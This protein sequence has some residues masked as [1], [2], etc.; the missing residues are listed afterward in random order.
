ML[1]YAAG[2]RQIQIEAFPELQKRQFY[3]Q[4][5]ISKNFSLGK[6]ICKMRVPLNTLPLFPTPPSFHS[7][8]SKNS[9]E[10][11][12]RNYFRSIEFCNGVTT[13]FNAKLLSKSQLIDFAQNQ[14]AYKTP[15]IIS[16]RIVNKNPRSLCLQQNQ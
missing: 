11:K 12:I 7:I 6:V 5:F 14:F 8:L 4:N 1:N 10:T 2:A 3:W 15:Q 16:F 13:C 9:L